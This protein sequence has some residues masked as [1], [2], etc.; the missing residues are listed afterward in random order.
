[1]SAAEISLVHGHK[2]VLQQ[3]SDWPGL[4]DEDW[5][6]I[7][8]EDATLH[9]TLQKQSLEDRKDLLLSAIRHLKRSN[10]Q[11]ILYLGACSPQCEKYHNNPLNSYRHQ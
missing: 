9:P 10:H 8:E 3:I 4:A 1:M 11:G 5:A 2:R 6:L 7:F